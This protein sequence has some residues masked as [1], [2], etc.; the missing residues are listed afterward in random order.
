MED[1]TNVEVTPVTPSETNTEAKN[2]QPNPGQQNSVDGIFYNQV[3]EKLNAIN[4]KL[5]QGFI[6]K[7]DLVDPYVKPEK[8][9]FK[10][11]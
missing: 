1:N 8:K 7:V 10:L 11:G 3:M 6:Q 9:E 4:S 5:E 2:I